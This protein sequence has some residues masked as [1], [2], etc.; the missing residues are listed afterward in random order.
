MPPAPSTASQPIKRGGSAP[1]LISVRARSSG[2][3]TEPIGVAKRWNAP[4][5]YSDTV[6]LQYLCNRNR[7]PIAIHVTKKSLE[8]AS[9]A[10]F[11]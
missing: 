3:L 2:A 1:T 10:L 4:L 5:N 6:K 11:T 9:I 7:F 8:R